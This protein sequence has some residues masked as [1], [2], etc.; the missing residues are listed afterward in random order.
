MTSQMLQLPGP[1]VSPEWLQANL[2][3]VVVADV[4][5]AMDGGPKVAAYEVG[6]L[7]TAVFVD[8]DADLSAPPGP[9]GRHPLPTSEHFAVV[10]SRLGFVDRPVV[11][12]DDQSGAQAARLWWM[13]DAIGHPAAVL[14]GGIQ[15]WP[16]PLEAGPGT[17]NPAAVDRAEAIPWPADRFV[18]VDE[19][20]PAIANGSVVVDARSADRFAGKA[21]PIDARP[22]HIPGSTSRPWTDNVDEHGR[23]HQPQRLRDELSALGV[24]PGADVIASC[25]SGVTGCH[26]LL[27]ARVAGVGPGRLYT[28]S[29]SEWSND[30]E[31]PVETDD[32][33]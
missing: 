13:L 5:W 32:H 11:A 24:V 17:D 8:L 26:D 28:G 29:W 12:Y 3:D 30:P 16:G 19:V 9:A 7:P 2:D 33:A 22:G 20:I 27:A 25:G 10:R 18:D 4:R 23:L 1:L 15:A 14:D 31:R 6:H 21:N